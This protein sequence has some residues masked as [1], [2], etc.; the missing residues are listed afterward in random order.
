MV[1]EQHLSAT[2]V[3]IG[4]K[5]DVDGNRWLDGTPVTFFNYAD[6][7]PNSGGYTEPCIEMYTG[8]GEWNDAVCDKRVP[9]ICEKK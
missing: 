8:N 2:S 6:G 5:N 1:Y 7:E 9:F 3:W 4:M